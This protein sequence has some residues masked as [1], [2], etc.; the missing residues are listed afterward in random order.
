MLVPTPWNARSVPLFSWQ[1]TQVRLDTA[2]CPVTDSTGA[3]PGVPEIWKPPVTKLDAWQ[4]LALQVAVPIGIWL[5]SCVTSVGTPYQA[6]PVPWQLAH[7][8]EL[9]A[10]WPAVPSDGVEPILKAPTAMV[11]PWQVTQSPVPSAMWLAA[12]E[13][14]TV[15]GGT[16]SVGTPYQA[17]A[18][19]WQLA[20]VRALTAV[21]PVDDSRGVLVS[22]KPVPVI[23][24]T[25]AWHAVPQSAVLTGM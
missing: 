14:P 19:L 3:V 18:E 13:V 23:A 20:H 2:V 1:P 15:P 7:V 8:A 25:A 16:T 9:T 24:S 12:P 11:L 17:M 4:P 10:W 5:P 21:C 6:A 22:L